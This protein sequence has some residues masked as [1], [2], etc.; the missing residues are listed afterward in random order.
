MLSGQKAELSAKYTNLERVFEDI[1]AQLLE[2]KMQVESLAR[3][4]HQLKLELDN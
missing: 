4:N 1:R 3:E 2:S